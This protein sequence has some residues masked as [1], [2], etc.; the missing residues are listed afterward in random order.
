MGIDV[1]PDSVVRPSTSVDD[2]GDPSGGEKLFP[3]RGGSGVGLCLGSPVSLAWKDRVVRYEVK[4][5]QGLTVSLKAHH[6]WTIPRGTWTHRRAHFKG[7]PEEMVRLFHSDRLSQETQEKA[8][9]CS[10]TWTVL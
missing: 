9:H 3:G 5:N 2:S 7:K 6:S 8:G 10:P 4:L 1:D